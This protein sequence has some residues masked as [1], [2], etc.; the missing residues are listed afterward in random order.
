MKI[1][2][3][4]Q[5]TLIGIDEKRGWGKGHSMPC[6]GDAC[7]NESG[8]EKIGLK[9]KHCPIHQ[10]EIIAIEAVI[11]MWN[12]WKNCYYFI[13]IGPKHTEM[14]LMANFVVKCFRMV[15]IGKQSFFNRAHL[16]MNNCLSLVYY[17]I[18]ITD[19]LAGV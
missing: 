6:H 13:Y 8:Q 14:C 2:N 3:F 1:E 12:I 5:K 9:I 15:Y 4:A 19:Y 11:L 7:K 10:A 17:S 18:W 16:R